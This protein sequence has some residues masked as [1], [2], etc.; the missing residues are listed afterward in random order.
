MTGLALPSQAEITLGR[1]SD[2]API[3]LDGKVLFQVS[4]LTQFSAKDRAKQANDSLAQA[5]RDFAAAQDSSSVPTVEV[6]PGPLPTL[7]LGDRHLLT[8]TDRD[9]MLGK[10]PTDQA[11][12]WQIAIN[13][14]IGIGLKERT[15]TYRRKAILN[16]GVAVLL[17]IILHCGIQWVRLRWRRQQLRTMQDTKR[18]LVLLGL[19]GLQLLVWGGVGYYVC[20]LFPQ[21]RTLLYL[22]LRSFDEPIFSLNQQEYG[23]VDLLIVVGLILGLWAIVRGLT[24]LLKSKILQLLGVNRGLQDAIA[25][26]T[27]YVLTG[28]GVIVI[29]QVLGVD[30]SALLIVGSALGLGIGFGLQNIVSNFISGIILL[31]D[32][33]IEAGDFVNVGNLVGT[34]EKIG[35]R[36]TELRTLD[37]VTIIIPNAHFL[38]KEVVNWSHSSPVSRLH[39]P[40]DV[41]YGCDV[42]RVHAA[43]IE[44]VSH[45]SE[46]LAYPQPQ[47]QFLG[48]GESALNFD[49]LV[50]FREP[51]QQYRLKSELFFRIE[52]VLRQYEIE[53]P[54]PQRDLHVRSPHLD[55]LIDLLVQQRSEDAPH[56][57]Y[58]DSVRSHP[59]NQSISSPPK[60]MPKVVSRSL[61]PDIDLAE[62]VAQM[63]G[64]Q[65]LDIQDRR[66]RLNIYPQCFVGSE[67][68]I[69]LMKTQRATRKE[70]TRI[71]QLL[72]QKRI[73]HHV[74][75]EHPF[76]DA[77]LFYRFYEDEQHE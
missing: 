34:V 3:V 72:V 66:H 37:E 23:I 33:P 42:E 71:G 9:V 58:P 40:V 55:Q 5:I 44:S 28:L 30:L 52:A 36:S 64:E 24:L 56:L 10:Q 2:T 13:D 27:Q 18:P 47:V 68:V 46:V 60:P 59:P 26:L 25:I 57:Y 77:Y 20:D 45:H 65:G 29:L 7:R 48:F 51:R 62:L 15:P 67:A 39:L 43:L 11:V 16:S 17:A 73:I 1:S 12:E 21:S 19:T 49:V 50:W 31:L 41:A 35:T 6:A 70:A 53:V 22:V 4:K 8:V 63:R 14:A 32:R 54:F 69:W 38:E 61:S 76:D 75:D 74:L